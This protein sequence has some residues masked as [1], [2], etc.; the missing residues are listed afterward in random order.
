MYTGVQRMAIQSGNKILKPYEMFIAM[1]IICMAFGLIIFFAGRWNLSQENFLGAQAPDIEFQSNSGKNTSLSQQQGV[2]VLMNFWASWCI[3]CMEE[4]PS[5][6]MLENH[7]KKK[8]FLLLAFNIGGDRTESLAGKIASSKL[9]QNLV[10][11]FSKN[12]LK[13]YSVDSIPLSILIDKKGK[14]YKVYHGPQNWM[15]LS[16]LREIET[17]IKE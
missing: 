13:S 8:G 9:P 16:I 12:Q 6:T 5:L 4:M 2:V 10:F 7:L 11:N 14:I 15:D 1:G 3:P 17:V